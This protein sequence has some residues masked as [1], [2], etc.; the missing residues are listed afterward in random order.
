MPVVAFFALT[1][2]LVCV[3]FYVG[4]RTVVRQERLDNE[5]VLAERRVIEMDIEHKRSLSDNLD[6]EFQKKMKLTEAACK[7]AQ[8]AYEE[9]VKSLDSEYDRRVKECG[10]LFAER[11]KVQSDM[12]FEQMEQL[13][14]ETSV[15][16]RSLAAIRQTRVSAIEAAKKETEVKNSPEKYS[17]PM[18]VSEIQDIEYLDTVMQRLNYPEVIGKCIWSV[19]FQK[20]MKGFLSNVLGPDEVCGVYKITDQRTGEPYIGQARKIK[21]RW[22]THVKCGIGATPTANANLLYA[23]MRRDG[24]WNFTFELLEACQPDELD[25]KERWFID[26]YSADSVGLNAKKGNQSKR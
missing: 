26:L 3:S 2:L 16:E 15:Y 4:K 7:S 17:I 5:K 14:A 9:K 10:R 20:K 25:D 24:V 23:A 22:Q 11:F 19:Y 8:D 1:A 13:A 18:A 21:E 12:H 6:A